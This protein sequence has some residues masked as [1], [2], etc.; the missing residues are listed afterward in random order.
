MEIVEYLL[1]SIDYIIEYRKKD[2]ENKINEGGDNYGMSTYMRT[3]EIENIKGQI[4][5]HEEIKNQILIKI[6]E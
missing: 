3:L 5:A 2:L 6:N 4:Q 1:K